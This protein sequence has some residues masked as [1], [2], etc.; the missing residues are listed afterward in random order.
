MIDSL[1]LAKVFAAACG[2]VALTYGTLAMSGALRP[3]PETLIVNAKKVVKI[4]VEKRGVNLSETDMA[5][6]IKEFDGLVVSEAERIHAQTGAVILNAN[7]ILAGGR[8]VSEPF[9]DQVIAR[10]DAAQ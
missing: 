7:H 10:W 6:A 8:D 3:Q 1:T 9:A 2:V 4:F 5:R